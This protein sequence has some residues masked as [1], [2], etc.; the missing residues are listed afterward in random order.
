MIED[1]RGSETV[2]S[3]V[4]A[5]ASY[6]RSVPDAF[7]AG[8]DAYL[9]FIDRAVYGSLIVRNQSWTQERFYL[10]EFHE[11]GENGLISHGVK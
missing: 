6:P 10:D 5:R 1:R 4:V 9:W 11:S 3:F 2:F 8:I 7:G